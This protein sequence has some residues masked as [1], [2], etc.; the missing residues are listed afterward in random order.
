MTV[1]ALAASINYIE[2][3][4]TL[5]FAAP[6]RFLANSIAVSRV[7]T[8]GTVVDLVAGVDFSASGGSTDA[9]GAVTLVSSVAGATLRIRRETPRSQAMDYTPGDRFPA[10]SHE[11]AIDRAMLIDQEQDDRIADVNARAILVPDGETINP[12]DARAGKGGYV[13]GLD[14]GTP[15]QPVWVRQGGADSAFRSDMAD[16]AQGVALAAFKQAGTGAVGRT[17]LAKARE[18]LSPDDFGAVGDGVVDD[19]SAVNAAIAAIGVGGRVFLP[20]GKTYRVTSLTN[21]RNVGFWGDG[22]ITIGTGNAAYAIRS[23]A[24]RRGG[25]VYGREHLSRLFA[26]AG[27]AGTTLKG[28]YDSD[29]TGARGN[30]TIQ[31]SIT[32]NVLTVTN[33]GSA[34]LSQGTFLTSVA[35]TPRI[36]QQLTG[37]PFGNGTYSVSTSPNVGAGTIT[38]GNGGGFAGDAGEPQVLLKKHF[39]LNGV[40]NAVNLVNIGIGGSTWQDLVARNPAQ[41]LDANSDLLI[42]KAPINR[43]VSDAA[44]IASM[45]QYFTNLRAATYGRVDLLT[46]VLEGY[47]PA[48]DTTNGRTSLYAQRMFEACLQCVDDFDVVFVDMASIY[49]AKPWMVGTYLDASGAHPVGALQQQILPQVGRAII[50]A[51]EA[52][53]STG[54][55]WILLT[56]PGSYL[57]YDNGFG[58]QRLRLHPHGE[59]DLIGGVRPPATTVTANDTL[60]NC[61][62][63]NYYPD[64]SIP[65]EAAVF[66]TDTSWSKIECGV[67][68]AGRG[69]ARETVTN[70]TA[71]LF[72]PGTK[73][74]TF[75][76]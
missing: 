10:E 65:I 64:V 13:L 6:F 35:G 22:N 30:T 42:V 72:R 59:V 39:R 15:P 3:G 58:Q 16:P 1:A 18:T 31:G 50:Q 53:L 68:V 62:N 61:P 32:S 17:M 71:I 49:A 73:W 57:P 66:K 34:T 60:F 29:S 74:S 36:I 11:A 45:R 40:R 67:D 70:V 48:H 5:V 19:T 52:Q 28:F 33:A 55:D 14:A 54:D 23:Y 27:S 9:G 2:N 25:P 12:V 41:Y 24:R 47:T 37:T 56:P 38:V 69:F 43:G 75:T 46:I 63:T 4:V 44:D 26:R 51:G 20:A 21:A 8:D 76:S 7:L